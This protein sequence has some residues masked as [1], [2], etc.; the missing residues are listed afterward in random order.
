MTSC[1]AH[2]QSEAM[3]DLAW[4]WVVAVLHVTLLVAAGLAVRQVLLVAVSVFFLVGLLLYL[5]EALLSL[6]TA[7]E[8]MVG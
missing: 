8:Y 6:M 1:A 7:L 5:L 2:L 3:L 4:Q